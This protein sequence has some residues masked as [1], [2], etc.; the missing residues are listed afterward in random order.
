LQEFAIASK[1]IVIS[2]PETI[3]KLHAWRTDFDRIMKKSAFIVYELNSPWDSGISFVFS[4]DDVPLSAIDALIELLS[5]ITNPIWR[6]APSPPPW[7][8]HNIPVMLPQPPLW[9]D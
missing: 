6:P 4:R 8:R 5:F 3:R 2:H 1:V 7:S 9:P